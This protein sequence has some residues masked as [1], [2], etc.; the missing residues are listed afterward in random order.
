MIHRF[1]LVAL[2]FCFALGVSV[3]AAETDLRETAYSIDAELKLL[4]KAVS[5][6]QKNLN[7]FNAELTR[8]D[9]G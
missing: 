2:L 4:L 8:R 3:S 9:L 1:F 7:R 6:T 5:D